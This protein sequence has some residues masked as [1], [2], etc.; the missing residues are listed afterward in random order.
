MQSKTP[1]LDALDPRVC[2]NGKV[3][4]LARLVAAIYDSML[5]PHGLQG[6][7][8]SIL[9]IIGKL[10]PISQK[11]LCERMIMEQSTMSREVN[12][13]IDKGWIE[14][15]RAAGDARIGQLRLTDEGCRLVE[16]MVP[17]WQQ[18]HD[19]VM[20]VLGTFSVQQL[21]GAVAALSSNLDAL[22]Q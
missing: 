19:K 22:K 1:N 8:L 2:V 17:V 15:E 21:D 13:L 20:A 7:Q 16:Q 5:R 4:K 3:R 6:S 12:R 10:Q 9:F 18:T 11:S 14:I